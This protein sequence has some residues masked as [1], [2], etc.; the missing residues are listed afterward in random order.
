MTRIRALAL[1][2]L[3]GTLAAP[4]L[5]NDQL[6]LSLGVQPGVYSTAELSLLRQAREDENPVLER[7]ILEAAGA[8]QVG[9]LSDHSLGAEE[10][11]P[12]AAPATLGVGH[13]RLAASLGL[14]GDAY[15]TQ[16]LS[17]IFIDRH[18]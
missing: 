3:A 12:A 11:A 15:T 18:N 9:F 2:A 4:A 14:D 8:G 13:D 10:A 7:R 1:A 16:E 17:A 6:A 5:A